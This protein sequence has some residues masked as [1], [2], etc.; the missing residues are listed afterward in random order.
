MTADSEMMTAKEVREYLGISPRKMAALIE[1]N[2]FT[3]K[4]DPLD[5]RVKL[6]PRA[7][8]E[9]LAQQSERWGK[10]EQAA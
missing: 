6:I 3:V 7:E 1:E 8:V 4:V 10:V 9:K 5:K 2:A